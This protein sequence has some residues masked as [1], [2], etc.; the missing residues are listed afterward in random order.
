MHPFASSSPAVRVNGPTSSSEARSHS[1]KIFRPSRM[2][3]QRCA[4]PMNAKTTPTSRTSHF[5]RLPTTFTSLRPMQLVFGAFHDAPR[6]SAIR[7]RSLQWMFSTTMGR[8]IR[9]LIFERPTSDAPVALLVCSSRS[10]DDVHQL[11][12]DRFPRAPRE[13][14]TAS[15]TRDAFHRDDAEKP[16]DALASTRLPRRRPR[17]FATATRR[18]S[19]FR[20]ARSPALG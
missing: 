11:G 10:R 18:P 2:C 19:T 16:D 13:E 12:R 14:R 9:K 15:T 7:S 17:G 5:A 4:R 3:D 6:A 20:P 1:S 8:E